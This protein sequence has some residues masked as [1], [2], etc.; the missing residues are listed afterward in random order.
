[1]EMVL[2]VRT[3]SK[4]LRNL[5]KYPEPTNKQR[6]MHWSGRELLA[7]GAMTPQLEFK[8]TV[9]SMLLACL[10][11]WHIP[12]GTIILLRFLTN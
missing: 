12:R 1:M 9:E 5:T 4:N 3:D 7:P 11:S 6:E 10:V 2:I 8:S